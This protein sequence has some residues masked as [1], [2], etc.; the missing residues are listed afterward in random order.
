MSDAHRLAW[1]RHP[2]T[3]A[4]RKQLME[5]ERLTTEALMNR[6]KHSSDPMV[7]E[8]YSA[9]QVIKLA[10]AGMQDTGEEE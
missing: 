2:S 5:Q 4:L 9:L 10:L 7:R 8:S 6:A 3:R 1:L